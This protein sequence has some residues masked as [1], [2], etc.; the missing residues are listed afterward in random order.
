LRV[1]KG[2]W[3]TTGSRRQEEGEHKLE[4]ET[5]DKMEVHGTDK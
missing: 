4:E 1:W 5:N 2:S 3:N